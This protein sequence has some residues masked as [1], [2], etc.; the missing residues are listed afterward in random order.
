MRYITFLLL[1]MFLGLSSNC[2]DK[3]YPIII[4]ETTHGNIEIELYEETPL[5]SD[6]FVKLVNENFY[7]GI[8][9]H[10]VIKDF[11]IQAGDPTSK[12]AES[13]VLL[14]S[15]GPGYTIPAEIADNY[16]HKRGVLSSARMPD[17]I[18]PK[19]ESSG[20]QFFIVQGRIFS[21][22]EL[23]L[24]EKNYGIQFSPEQIKAYSTIGG[25]PHLDNQ[26]TI[27]G[28]VISGMDIVD[29]I[30]DQPTDK[31]NRPTDDIKI[32]R[33]YTK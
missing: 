3:S 13:G 5:H 7:D 29:K 32:I 25:A 19:R 23:S 11:M 20:S 21:K 2:N 10:R 24:L 31:N 12:D 16:Y 15:K 8:L 14:G 18:N 30:S 17:N 1:A 33:A 28:E 26:Y 4:F 27:F 6:N 9:F 22:E